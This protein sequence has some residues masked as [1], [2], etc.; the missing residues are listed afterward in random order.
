MTY[1]EKARVNQVTG[2]INPGDVL[3]AR[4][5]MQK[6][7][8][9]KALNLN[10]IEAGPNN[11][12]GFVSS[13]LV[14]HQDESGNTIYAG[15]FTG[16]LWKTTN[17]GL[18]WEKINSA[19]QNIFVSSLDQANDGTIYAATGLKDQFVGQGVYKSTNG[20]DFELI[21]STNPDHKNS[22]GAWSYVHKIVVGPNQEIY[23]ATNTGLM[24]STDGGSSW[25]AAATSEGALEGFCYDVEVAGNGVIFTAIEEEAYHSTGA[26]ADFNMISGSADSLL[27]SGAARVKFAA[28]PSEDA[29]VYAVAIDDDGILEGVYLTGNSGIEW[30]EI[31]PGGTDLLNPFVIDGDVGTGL[32]TAS[33]IVAPNDA[34]TVYIGGSVVFRGTAPQDDG[35]YA[36]EKPFFSFQPN[37]P[38][39]VHSLNFS[40]NTKMYIASEY[41]VSS[42]NTNPF[43]YKTYNNF[44]D[45]SSFN[46]VSLGV[47]DKVLGGENKFGVLHFPLFGGQEEAA[48]T[49]IPGTGGYAERS[50]LKENNIIISLEATSSENMFRSQDM[51][52]AF[53]QNFLKADIGYSGQTQYDAQFLQF[54]LWESFNNPESEEVVYFKAVDTSY[55]AGDVVYAESYPEKY[56]I[57]VTLDSDLN[58]GDSLAVNDYITSRLFVAAE[59]R[60]AELWMTDEVHLYGVEPVWFQIAEFGDDELPSAIEVS[61]DGDYVYVGMENGALY[62]VGNLLQANDSASAIFDSGSSVVT[63]DT[64]FYMEDRMITSVSV[65]PNNN[66]HVIVTLGNYGNESYVYESFNAT[67][68]NPDYSSIQFNLPSVPVYSSLVEMNSSDRVLIGSEFGI[69]A[70][71]NDSWTLEAGDM[72]ALPVTQLRQQVLESDDMNVPVGE[73]GGETIYQTFKGITNHGTIYAS[74]YGRGV[75]KSR[76]FVGFDDFVDN[77]SASISKISIYPNP[78]TDLA[79]LNLNDFEADQADVRVLDLQGRVVFAKPVSNIKGEIKINVGYLKSGHYLVQVVEGENV[80][81]TKMIVR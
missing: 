53:G 13:I 75:W 56:P 77:N 64:V 41:G 47:D 35:Y 54:K 29:R 34:E 49:I 61:K 33:I 50:A 72:G 11:Y 12:G 20:V 70:L 44:L 39:G 25:T 8:S 69:F 71:E 38:L 67:T 62:R 23:T 37:G 31:G 76:N 48:E 59:D 58:N 21:P 78:V 66:D 24:V 45:I 74:T 7:S 68:A 73:L 4:E 9:N 28:A 46:S 27:P 60:E 63:N 14:D 19:G 43:E 55:S 80:Q 10:W 32:N 57:K 16:G 79:T 51:G 6:M 42:F 3:N 2:Q 40:S 65:D 18:I 17:G 26:I 52:E 30:R 36:W 15:A 81:T 22:D 5:E 1:M